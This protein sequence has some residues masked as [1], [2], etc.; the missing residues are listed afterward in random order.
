MKK[1]FATAAI[2]LDR[3]LLNACLPLLQNAQVDAIEWSFD[4]LF[5]QKELP[6]WFEH[7]VQE[8]SNQNRLIGHGIYY[9]IFSGKFSDE[10]KQWLQEL[11]SVCKKYRFAHITEHFGFLTGA[12]FHKGAPMS[13]PFN[14][15]TLSL[16]QDRLKRL[17]VHCECPV[18]IENLAFAFGIDDVK[19][20]GEFLAKL[21]EPINGF[22]I[23]DLHNLYCQ[24]MNFKLN[25][26]DIIKFY[27]LHLVR[28]I[29][30]SGGS[31][32][33]FNL[34]KIRR[35]T[36]DDAVPNEVFEY[37]QFLM[38]RC[39]NLQYVTME[40]MGNALQNEE[41]VLQFRNDF[42][43]MS[44]IC[45]QSPKTDS[46][47]NYFLPS[48]ITE[49][50]AIPIENEQLHIEQLTLTDILVQAKSVEDAKH[51]LRNSILNKSSWEFE[52]WTDGMLHTAMEITQKWKN[53]FV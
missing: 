42:E 19:I 5:N 49:L 3:H 35:D 53:G 13:V 20:H 30:I 50:S 31:W 34:E 12:D 43:R 14:P 2:N 44:A 37:L 51:D 7:L 32:D 1:L 28:E 18:G 27:P 16:G 8:F 4:A 25:I 36:H 21:V 22:I 10:Q 26:E 39:D 9:S 38:N 45:K 17:Q 40:Q 24:V 11:A 33:V 23:L 52:K 46:L 29:H 48:L 47:N 15:T 6:Y 41:D